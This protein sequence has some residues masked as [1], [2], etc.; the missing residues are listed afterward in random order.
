MKIWSVYINSYYMGTVEA[1]SAR[2]AMCMAFDQYPLVG[3][4]DELEVM[5]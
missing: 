4:D 1:R 3:P 5:A 2:E